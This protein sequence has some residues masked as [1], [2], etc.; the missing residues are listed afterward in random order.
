[1]R[2]LIVAITIFLVI[3]IFIGIH[4]YIMINLTNRISP[5][6]QET[7]RFANA[8][9]WDKVIENID[10]IQNTWDKKRLWASLTISTKNIEEIEISLKQSRAFAVL[11][12]KS[13][14]M[15]EFIMFSMLLDHIPHQE[16]FGIEEIL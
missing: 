4:S 12:A 15:G 2:A 11:H 9:Q 14:F 7:I 16:G 3:C 6:C 5:I 10:Q 1:M 8:D 13:D